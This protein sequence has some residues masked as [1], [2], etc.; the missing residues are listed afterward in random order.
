MSNHPASDH[1]SGFGGSLSDCNLQGDKILITIPG[2]EK[3]R[4]FGMG[5]GLKAATE[6]DVN[7]FKAALN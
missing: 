2:S 5:F 1:Q 6:F 4:T 3:P 7:E